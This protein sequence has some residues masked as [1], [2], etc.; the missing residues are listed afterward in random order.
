MKSRLRKKQSDTQKNTESGSKDQFLDLASLLLHDLEGPLAS[1]IPA[2]DG[3]DPTPGAIARH[4]GGLLDAL[5]VEHGD[6]LLIVDGPGPTVKFQT[7]TLGEWLRSDFVVC[8]E[9]EC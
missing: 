8:V 7:T 1:M 3:D 2:L 5:V 9:D 4:Y 6:D